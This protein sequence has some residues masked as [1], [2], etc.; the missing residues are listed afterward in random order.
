MIPKGE[1]DNDEH[2]D[3]E[4]NYSFV[5]ISV[6]Y[7]LLCQAKINIYIVK[8]NHN[9][10][11]DNRCSVANCCDTIYYLFKDLSVQL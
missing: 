4:S 8:E 11:L 7:Y 9:N 3:S 2:E 10:Q 6:L 1:G 5:S